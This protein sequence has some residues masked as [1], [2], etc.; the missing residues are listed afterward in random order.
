MKTCLCESDDGLFVVKV[1]PKQNENEDLKLIQDE[2]IKQS[3]DIDCHVKI[4]LLPYSNTYDNKKY[5][6]ALIVRQYL[7][8]TLYHR[9]KYFYIYF[10]VQDH[11]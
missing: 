10:L 11:F 3:N 1:Y 5:N 7:Y 2:I 9:V 4:N 6:V 8:S